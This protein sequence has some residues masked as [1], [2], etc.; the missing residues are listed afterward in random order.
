MAGSLIKIAETT[1]SSAVAS[2][3][4][5][6]IDSTY[7][8]AYLQMDSNTSF[9]DV[10]S[11]T[12][13]SLKFNE[14]DIRPEGAGFQIYIYNPFSSSSFTF[15]NWQTASFFS[16]KLRGTKAIGVEHT[17]QSI[18]GFQ[19]FEINTRPFDSGTISIY[20]VN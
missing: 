15:A 2:V 3:T 14:I 6:G 12:A 1:V 9:T 5:T 10:S 8:Y 13:T 18:R 19:L 20:G 11:T 4:L 17:A 7:D 16:S